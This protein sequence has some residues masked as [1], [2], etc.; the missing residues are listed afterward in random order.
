MK[1]KALRKQ[2]ENTKIKNQNEINATKE[3]HYHLIH[4]FRKYM[5]KYVN[6]SIKQQKNNRPLKALAAH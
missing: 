2:H 1:G 6:L 3:E 4:Y 5:T